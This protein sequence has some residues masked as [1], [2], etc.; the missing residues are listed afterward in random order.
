MG[1]VP[2]LQLV[3]E[4]AVGAG[5][6]TIVVVNHSTKTAVE[7]Y[8]DPAPE[9]LLTLERAGKHELAERL[10]RVESF[11]VRFVHQPEP[12]G[13][14]HAVGMAKELVG[15]EPFAVLLPDELMGSSGLLS[16][17][18]DESART[19]GS[20][21]GL[22]QVPHD[23][24]SA[25]GVVAPSGA[26]AANGLVPVTDLVEKP[27]VDSAPSDLV[28]IGRYVCTPGVMRE[29]GSLT[30]G[31]GGEL[32]LTDALRAV[33]GYE[34]FFGLVGDALPGGLVRYDTGNPAGWLQAVVEISLGHPQL[35]PVMRRL[36]LE[37]AERERLLSSC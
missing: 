16:E 1:E 21:V 23:Q 19:G 2:G 33:A 11:D 17:M 8:F 18:L 20:V 15:D 28:I 5:I 13:L 6:E 26:V 3:I 7:R 22:K 34:P 12:L 29:I 25:Y 14:G 27:P 4:E 35:G 37:I 36:V 10:R 30:P 31:A 24:V 32:Q 9:L